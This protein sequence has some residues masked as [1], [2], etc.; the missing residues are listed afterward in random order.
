MLFSNFAS[1]TVP[2]AVGEAIKYES[3][4]TS[5]LTR[6]RK[7]EAL[8]MQLASRQL[9]EFKLAQAISK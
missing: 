4:T 9:K 8:L 7:L 5:L 6:I 2:V 1:K 3:E